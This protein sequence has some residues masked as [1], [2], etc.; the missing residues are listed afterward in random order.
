MFLGID[1]SLTSTGLAVVPRDGHQPAVLMNIPTGSLRGAHRLAH[2]R[3]TLRDVIE[4]TRP[5]H[6][7]L[8]GYSFGSV[9][10]SFD[11]GEVGGIVR[12]MLHDYRIP[13]LAVPPTSLKK[14]VVNKSEATKEDMMA[15]VE[16]RWQQVIDQDDA[17][18]AYCLAKVARQL[19][20][21]DSILRY[22]LEVI[23]ALTKPK[24]KKPSV[25]KSRT[26]LSL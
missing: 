7:A 14:F 24:E 23:H 26:K 3:D 13:F 20:V 10:R 11:L 6:A 2:I 16:V 12:L 22:E 9:N 1:Q 15:G 17:C 5:V 8:E 18:D 21:R 19:V 25:A 4:A